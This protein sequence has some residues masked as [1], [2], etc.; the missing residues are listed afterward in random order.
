M[1]NKLLENK[2][3]LI[4]IVAVVL[5]LVGVIIAFFITNDSEEVYN[6]DGLEVED[7]LDE[8]VYTINGSGDWE[9]TSDDSSKKEQNNK[10]DDTKKE[11]S[12]NKV[13]DGDSLE[14][15]DTLD[16]SV[17]TID[18]SGDWDGTSDDSSEK[19]QNSET[20]DTKKEES[21]DK[22]DAADGALDKDIL[23]DDKVW[24]EPS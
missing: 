2:K 10:T 15:E 20:D 12:D 6:G 23:E 7:T 5:V 24:G 19:E 1:L 9:G 22:V 17:Y 3:W 16:E 4:L 14:V 21:N 8:S 13:Y 18:G 11:E